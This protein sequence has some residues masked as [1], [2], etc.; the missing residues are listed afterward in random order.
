[1]LNEKCDAIVKYLNIEFPESYIEQANIR[2]EQYFKIPIEKGLLLL[3][4][5]REFIEDN[6]IE[7]ILSEFNKQNIYTLLHE[8]PKLGVFINQK[9]PS[10]FERSS[11]L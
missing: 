7:D 10:L 9:G 8:N 4:V 2:D 1:M 3:K 11:K 6:S 5:N